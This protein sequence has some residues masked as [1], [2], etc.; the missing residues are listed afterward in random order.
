MI[1]VES[2]EVGVSDVFSAVVNHLTGTDS[3][4]DTPSSITPQSG[5]HANNTQRP[6]TPQAGAKRLE[7]GLH[8]L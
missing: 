6:S 5:S 3:I 4:N 7:L 2:G 1:D 8:F